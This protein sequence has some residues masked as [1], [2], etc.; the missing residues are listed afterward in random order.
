[1]GPLNKHLERA[2]SVMDSEFDDYT[3]ASR[4]VSDTVTVDGQVLKMVNATAPF[5][6][7]SYRHIRGCV[8]NETSNTIIACVGYHSKEC[9]NEIDIDLKDCKITQCIE[10]TVYGVFHYLNTWFV[11]THRKFDAFHS[12][13]MNTKVTYGDI[14][15]DALKRQLDNEDLDDINSIL[16]K[17][18]NKDYFYKFFL[19]TNKQTR[20]VS[21]SPFE[22][23]PR[24]F[25]LRVT[26]LG[27][28]DVID[29]D[30]F[31]SKVTN[32]DVHYR[33]DGDSVLDTVNSYTY[34]EDGLSH[35][36]GIFIQ[37]SDGKEYTV[38]NETYNFLNTVIRNNNKSLSNQ[39]MHL[40][41]NQDYI[42][43]FKMLY[44]KDNA[45]DIDVAIEKVRR[46]NKWMLAVLAKRRSGVY[47][48]TMPEM[49]H[50]VRQFEVRGLLHSDLFTFLKTAEQKDV[51]LIIRCCNNLRHPWFIVTQLK[52]NEENMSPVVHETFKCFCAKHKIK[53]ITIP[54]SIE[55]MAIE[56]YSS[57]HKRFCEFIDVVIKPA[58]V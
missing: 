35:Y 6:D 32:F 33:H 3:P 14:F 49:W 26:V 27:T 37:S 23:I 46:L 24:L 36:K 34:D 54:T 30:V 39:Y 22:G 17:Y 16:D 9:V 44:G 31:D 50:L 56:V 20:F 4:P 5:I 51:Q 12:K 21:S 10:G 55:D 47:I 2:R 15:L 29:I 41:Y 8:Y 38:V 40:M 19:S 57:N 45:A 25:L 11:S 18:L 52:A 1:M 58:L 42:T 7:D 43:K 28:D 13:I 53:T 48:E